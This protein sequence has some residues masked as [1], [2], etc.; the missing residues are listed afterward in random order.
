LAAVRAPAAT[1][2]QTTEFLDVDVHEL[3]GT[4]TLVAADHT[5]G[6][7]IHPRQT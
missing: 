3:A 1:I 7:A 2:A 6:W 5:P 4:V